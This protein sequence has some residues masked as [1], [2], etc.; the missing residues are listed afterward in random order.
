MGVLT[1]FEQWKSEVHLQLTERLGIGDAW[2]ADD[3]YD[4][5]EIASDAFACGTSPVDFIV[6][7]F[8]DHLAAQ[9]YDEV[10]REEALAYDGEPD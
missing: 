8:S 4:L 1:P 7:A 2:D 10:T 9:A 3:P 5:N 6:D